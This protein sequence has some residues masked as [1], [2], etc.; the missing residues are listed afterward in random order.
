M[1][2]GSDPDAARGRSRP[3]FQRLAPLPRGEHGAWG[4]APRRLLI[5]GFWSSAKG[6]ATLHWRPHRAGAP[7]HAYASGKSLGAHAALFSCPGPCSL[8]GTG[9]RVSVRFHTA[10]FLT[11]RP[12]RCK[13]PARVPGC[14]LIPQGF[15]QSDGPL[16]RAPSGIDDAVTSQRSLH[17]R[18]KDIARPGIDTL[19]CSESSAARAGC[20][21]SGRCA[22]QAR[23]RS[24]LPAD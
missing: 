6:H 12:A 23:E 15:T 22:S 2:R 3:S 1:T 11:F 18:F 10:P 13:K 24:Q 19:R 20:R 7:E 17:R 21:R 5:G 8:H 9:A 16:K 4:E 14:S